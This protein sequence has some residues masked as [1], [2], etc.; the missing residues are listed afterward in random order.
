MTSLRSPATSSLILVCSLS[1]V[2]AFLIT[3]CGGSRGVEPEDTEPPVILARTPWD[4]ARDVGLIERLEVRFSEPLDASTVNDT[5]LLVSGRAPR[6]RIDYDPGTKTATFTPDSLYASLVWHAFVVT[7]DITDEAGNHLAAPDT[8]LFET[9][10]LDCAHLTDYL[11]P[12]NAVADAASI[13]RAT[14]YQTL[15]LCEDDE[16]V[17]G[18]AAGGAPAVRVQAVIRHAEDVDVTVGFL[19]QDGSVFADTT[20]LSVISGTTVSFRR[21]VGPDVRWIRIAATDV[22]TYVLYDLEVIW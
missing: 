10:D 22:A 14:P 6:G 20:S 18:F 9:G 2:S 16:D 8:V 19:S 4:G 11:E 15:A 12:N 17:F 13:D 7:E 21:E 3:S 1:L 5:T